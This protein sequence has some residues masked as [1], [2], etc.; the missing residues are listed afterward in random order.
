MI[1]GQLDGNRMAYGQNKGFVLRRCASNLWYFFPSK[2]KPPQFLVHVTEYLQVSSLIRKPWIGTVFVDDAAQRS[3]VDRAFY[4]L[5][6]WSFCYQL[7]F[8]IAQNRFD[9][10]SHSTFKRSSIF[11]FLPFKATNSC[12]W[13]GRYRS[14]N[15]PL[16]SKS[17]WT[18]GSITPVVDLAQRQVR[19]NFQQMNGSTFGVWN[20]A[21]QKKRTHIYFA[22][23]LHFATI[24]LQK[25]QTL[26]AGRA[27]NYDIQ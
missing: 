6:G 4:L 15:T 18:L 10:S 9:L 17:L 16:C 20:I 26:K 23:N 1:K 24:R 12:R 21:N 14:N 8:F 22:K 2:K 3:L 7:L 13:H 11:A 25:L 5:A 27:K 19:L